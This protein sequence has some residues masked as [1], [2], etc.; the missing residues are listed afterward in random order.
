MFIK[1]KI[2]DINELK[3]YSVMQKNQKKNLVLC[4]GHFNII[5]PGHLRFLE[6]VQ[7]QGD[8]LIVAVQGINWL[9][10][11]NK[12]VFFDEKERAKSVASLHNVDKVIIFNDIS[13]LDVIKAVKPDVYV[14]GEEF[15]DQIQHI[16]TEID[17]VEKFGGKVAFSAGQVEYT[18][19]SFLDDDLSDQD[20]KNR[21]LF[22]SALNRQNISIST[23]K[24]YCSSFEKANVLVIGDTMVDHYIACDALGMSAEA[25]ILNIRELEAKSFV[26][27]AAVVSRHV[28]AL[29]A[30]CYYISAIGDDDPGRFVQNEL[31]KDDIITELIIDSTRQTTFKIRYMVGSQKI[32]RVSR[33]QEHHISQKIQ[34]Q[35]L[36]YISSLANKLDGIIMSDFNYGTIT[37]YLI[38]QIYEISNRYGIKLFGDSQSS[39]QIGDVKKFINFD[40]ITPTEREARIALGDNYSGLEKIA[41]TLLEKTKVKNLVITLGENGFLAYE[42]LPK[43]GDKIVK[44]Q[45]FPAL[46]VNPPDVV[47]AGDSLLSA[48]SLSMCRGANSME[49]SAIANIVASIAVNKVGNIPVKV[50]EVQKWID[51]FG[52]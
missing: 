52:K 37:P 3:S 42:N 32:I 7:Q 31:N 46:T 16:K 15:S 24:N 48:Y 4:Q 47:G 6:F 2:I 5:H 33:L 22:K 40:L 51:K 20:A 14:R 18:S 19:S 43:N 36:N 23:L 35:I 21:N 25:P 41:M 13:I 11:K 34:D 30:K 26:G 44:S 29:G 9:E 27:G 50:D 17:L 12:S 10:E 8:I 28:K 49:A 45:H 38:S 1:D 39:S